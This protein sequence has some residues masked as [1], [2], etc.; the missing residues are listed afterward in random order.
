MAPKTIILLLMVM[1]GAYGYYRRHHHFMKLFHPTGHNCSHAVAG[2][3]PVDPDMELTTGQYFSVAGDYYVKDYVVL[4]FYICPEEIPSMITKPWMFDCWNRVPVPITK[5]SSNALL[6][7]KLIYYHNLAVTRIKIPRN[8]TC[9]RCGLQIEAEVRECMNCPVKDSAST[10]AFIS[11]NHIVDSPPNHPGRPNK[12][13]WQKRPTGPQKY[14]PMG[15]YRSGR[16]S[17]P[18]RSVG[19]HRPGPY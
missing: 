7:L 8:I 18:G 2:G 17:R 4:R 12:H 10:C 15:P 3:V 19:T 16:P 5:D 9:N 1:Q 13:S 14:I 6:D 11:I